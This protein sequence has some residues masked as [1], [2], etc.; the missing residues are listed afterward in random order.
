[1]PQ[2]VRDAFG[3]G[4]APKEKIDS[5]VKTQEWK[6]ELDMR[7][8]GVGADTAHGKNSPW[9]NPESQAAAAGRQAG[10]A[11]KYAAEDVGIDRFNADKMRVQQREKEME[12]GAEVKQQE[13]EAQKQEGIQ[14]R[15]TNERIASI[16][17]P[18][19]KFR[20]TPLKQYEEGMPTSETLSIWDPSTGQLAGQ[21]GIEGPREDTEEAFVANM[22]NNLKLKPGSKEYDE[23]LKEYRVRKGLK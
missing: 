9:Y 4:P 8:A 11:A 1:M 7:N 5:P 23:A 2:N 22:I 16:R 17:N 10:V 15:Q 14:D 12:A 13:I 18:Q 19:E 21:Q 20:A 3:M 6:R